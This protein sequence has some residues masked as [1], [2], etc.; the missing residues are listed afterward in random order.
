[1]LDFAKYC[2]EVTE[3]NKDALR[4]MIIDEDIRDYYDC[5][6]D[7][8]HVQVGRVLGNVDDNPN[9]KQT[10]YWA[11]KDVMWDCDLEKVTT[12]LPKK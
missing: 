1:M 4:Q 2:Y 9:P 7:V 10:G 5:K 11:S 6:F 12:E 8:S 3:E